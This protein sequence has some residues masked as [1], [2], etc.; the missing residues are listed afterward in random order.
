MSKSTTSPVLVNAARVREAFR[1]GLFTA[2][3][4]ALPSLMGKNGD[5]RVRGRLNPLAV[6]A[7]NAGVKGE[8]YAGEK[9]T[10]ESK[11]VTLPLTKMSA[12][13]ARLKRP[14]S[15]PLSQV[16]TLAGVEGK[17]GRLSSAEVARAA[18]AVVAQRGWDQKPTGAVKAKGGAKAPKATSTA[19]VEG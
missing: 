4:A 1:A 13:G 5:G 12:A 14:E 19:P 18:E 2:P 3:D 16:R 7:F 8:Q 15:F 17:K 6:E 10:V 9:S 11:S